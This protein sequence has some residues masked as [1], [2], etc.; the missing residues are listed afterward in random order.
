MGGEN[1]RKKGEKGV[2]PHSTIA[3]MTPSEMLYEAINDLLFPF[4]ARRFVV[5]FNNL[6]VGT[7]GA[8]IDGCTDLNE[9]RF[10]GTHSVRCHRRIAALLDYL[11]KLTV[12]LSPVGISHLR[13]LGAFCARTA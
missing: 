3:A 4:V 1:S 7:L 8:A 10:S 9:L 6:E 5:R 2:T 11:P 12:P 13:C